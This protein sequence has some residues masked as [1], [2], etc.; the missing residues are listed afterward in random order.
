M[1][2]RLA[3]GLGGGLAGDASVH[4]AHAHLE[5]GG[6]QQALLPLPGGPVGRRLVLQQRH[7]RLQLPL[8][9]LHGLQ[10]RHVLLLEGA[11][12]PLRVALQLGLVG[13]QLVHQRLLLL[14]AQTQRRDGGARLRQATAQLAYLRACT[15]LALFRRSQHPA[16]LLLRIQQRPLGEQQLF[17]PLAPERSL[18]LQLHPQQL[19][20]LRLGPALLARSLHAHLSLLPL[21][22]SQLIPQRGHSVLSSLAPART[23]GKQVV[24]A[25]QQLAA[26][27][28]QLVLRL[29]AALD[30]GLQLG[31]QAPQLR[32]LG[33][34]GRQQLDLLPLQLH[35]L[36][37]VLLHEALHPLQ[38][39]VGALQ[40]LQLVLRLVQLLGQLLVELLEV[41]HLLQTPLVL[42]QGLLGLAQL[43]GLV[44]GHVQLVRLLAGLH[45]GL[46]QQ[47]PGLLEP[48]SDGPQLAL[49]AVLLHG[50]QVLVPSQLLQLRLQ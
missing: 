5:D 11:Q 40:L 21:Q 12:R 28:R 45:V 49:D 47:L 14:E 38:A 1:L 27:T 44:A 41:A 24:V 39:A 9:L 37:A 17:L 3:A 15:A 2:V 6:G 46:Q 13:L 25:G 50:P 29:V 7:L 10:H 33:L 26:Q 43:A 34:R 31:L 42:L 30:G 23:R 22:S 19:Q 8:L 36:V 35:G 48:A 32:L 20:H 18:A 4:D 16:A